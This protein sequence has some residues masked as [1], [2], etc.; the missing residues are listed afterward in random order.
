MGSGCFR[1]GSIIFDF[2]TSIPLA[3]LGLS[4]QHVTPIKQFR[5]IRSGND[6]QPKRECSKF[7][8]VKFSCHVPWMYH[9]MFISQFFPLD[10]LDSQA[11]DLG[12]VNEIYIF[13]SAN[14]HN[15][16]QRL[17]TLRTTHLRCN[18]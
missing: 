8:K 3:L 9:A 5:C 11:L 2:N 13:K 12:Q 7:I 15:S 4:A 14:S 10:F 1:H 17:A 18:V 16:S 6:V